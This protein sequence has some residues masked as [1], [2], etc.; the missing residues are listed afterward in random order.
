[1]RKISWSVLVE[2]VHLDTLE[3]GGCAPMSVRIEVFQNRESRQFFPKVWFERIFTMRPF[4]SSAIRYSQ[5]SVFVQDCAFDLPYFVKESASE[6]I[7]SV[8]ATLETQLRL[9]ESDEEQP[10]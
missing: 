6:V 1:M 5:E 10:E 4:E 3:F 2:T 7:A 8:V 9:P